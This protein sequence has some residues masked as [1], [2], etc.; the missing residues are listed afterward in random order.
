MYP[1]IGCACMCVRLESNPVHQAS[2]QIAFT[3]CA[4]SLALR[5]GFDGGIMIWSCEIT[6]HIN[7]KT[8]KHPVLHYVCTTNRIHYKCTSQTVQDLAVSGASPSCPGLQSLDTEPSTP[9]LESSPCQ[10]PHLSQ[11]TYVLNKIIIHLALWR[12]FSLLS[13]YKPTSFPFKMCRQG[14]CSLCFL[15]S[16]CVLLSYDSK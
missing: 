5:S 3:S 2:G 15:K 13:T 16:Q 4:L 12:N 9:S 11:H 8:L 14:N 7:A 10:S 1:F 6:C